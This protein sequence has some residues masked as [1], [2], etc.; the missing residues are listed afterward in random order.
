MFKLSSANKQQALYLQ[1]A[2]QNSVTVTTL[3]EKAA[4]CLLSFS[5]FEF[6][7]IW[8]VRDG[9]QFEV[10]SRT[11]KTSWTSDREAKKGRFNLLCWF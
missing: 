7:M 3:C 11:G 5:I 2:V 10:K 6:R 1:A 4:G 8:Y 9:H